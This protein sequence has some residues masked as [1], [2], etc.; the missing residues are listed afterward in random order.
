AEAHRIGLL[1]Q[2]VEPDALDAAVQRQ[3]E[4]LLRAGPQ[5]AAAAKALVR[6]A[7]APGDRDATDAANAALIAR[8]RVS[9]EGQ[10]GIGAFLE[11]RPPSWM[12]E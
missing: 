10:E 11:K 5:A 9:P 4:L 8:L 1:H 6:Q 7:A 3:V 12:P 2:L